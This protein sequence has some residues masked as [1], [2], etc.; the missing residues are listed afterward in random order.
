MIFQKIFKSQAANILVNLKITV[1]ELTKIQHD[2]ERLLIMEQNMESAK[3]VTSIINTIRD[4]LGVALWIKDISHRYIF[5]N[6]VC[7]ETILNCRENEVNYLTLEDFEKDP[8]ARECI[9][10]DKLVM[11]NQTTKRFIEHAVYKDGRSV[12]IDVIKSPRI[13]DGELIGTI[14]SGVIITDS[15]PSGIKGQKRTS[16]L[17]EIPVNAS[18]GTRKLIELLERR[19]V[20]RSGKELPE[21]YLERRKA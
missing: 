18:M 9:K 6:K 3:P 4:S 12:F 10:S 8:L 16:G 13:E 20:S 19:R 14:G 21:V 17:I 2:I 11:E 7:C 15:I 1:L 5:A